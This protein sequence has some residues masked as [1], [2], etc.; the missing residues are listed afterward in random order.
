[1][2]DGPLDV[3]LDREIDTSG[4]PPPSLTNSSAG[5]VSLDSV[6]RT[7]TIAHVRWLFKQ[8]VTAYRWHVDLAQGAGHTAATSWIMG[9]SELPGPSLEDLIQKVNTARYIMIGHMGSDIDHHHKDPVVD[10]FSKVP[11]ATDFDSL[12]TLVGAM[13]DAFNSHNHS[14]GPHNYVGYTIL[15]APL[16]T[17]LRIRSQGLVDDGMMSLSGQVRTRYRDNLFGGGTRPFGDDRYGSASFDLRFRSLATRPSVASALARA[18]VQ[19]TDSGPIFESDAVQVFF[20]KPMYQVPLSSSNLSVTGGSILQKDASWS[21][22]DVAVIRVSNMQAVSYT[23][24]A[25]GL[26]DPSGNPTL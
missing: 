24:T 26:T 23:V 18:G 4:V 8:I 3:E 19:E 11:E 12:V 10:S 14:V 17:V 21:S 20:T 22:P 1:L 13:R 5:P 16:M 25:T 7:S 9:A 6:S 15:S 2:V